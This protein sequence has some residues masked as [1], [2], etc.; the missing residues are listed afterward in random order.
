MKKKLKYDILTG[1]IFPSPSKNRVYDYSHSP[2]NKLGKLYDPSIDQLWVEREGVTPK[3]PNNKPYAV[4]ITHDVDLISLQSNKEN[5]RRIKHILKTWKQQK[6]KQNSILVFESLENIMNGIFS[7]QDPY[8]RFEDWLN[9]EQEVG[10]RSTFFFAPEYVLKPHY[11]DCWYK[12]DDI[13][14]FE[15]E[16]ISVAEL[17]REINRR[18]WEIGLHPSWNSYNSV[19]ELKHQKDQVEKVIENEIVSIRQH[20]L[21][22]DNKITPAVQSSAGFKY[23][24]TLG[25][26]D[27]IGFRRGTSY[28]YPLIDLVSNDRLP[29]WE[30][31]LIIQ[32]G[33]MFHPK[34]GMRLDKETALEYIQLLKEKV[35]NVGGILTLLWHPH[36]IVDEISWN[37][38]QEGL[39]ILQ[40]DDPWFASVREIGDWWSNN[41]KIDL[42]SFIENLEK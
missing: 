37:T 33:A 30:I 1:K 40:K 23:D 16:K 15:G 36:L 14:K 26:N 9:V 17:M 7:K 11:T 34:K 3:W 32:D 5:I 25:F 39:K 38:F 27:N 24:A 35:R 20:F 13:L 21:H 29:I 18:G 2:Q 22:F 42:V 41:V 19:D 31:P 12:Y 28:V 6:S 8:H 4:C 10:A